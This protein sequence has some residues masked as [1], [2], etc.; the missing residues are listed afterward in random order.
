MKNNPSIVTR[1]SGS[2]RALA[3][4]TRTLIASA[5]VLAI[6]IV[7]NLLAGLLP[8]SVV[9]YDTTPAGQF[10]VSATSK[11]FVK[12]LKEDV[13][14]YVMCPGGAISPTMEAFL[15]RYEAASP[16]L[17]VEVVDSTVDAAFTEKYSGA[18]SMT[19]YSMVVASARRYRLI[20][21]TN[22]SYYYINGL[23]E[24]PAATY[25]QMVQSDKYMEIAYQYYTQYGIDI[26]KATPY[27]RGE[28]ALT[29]AIEYV[30][31]ETIPHL[32][33]SQ[34]HG[35]AALGKQLRSFFDQVGMTCDPL[36]ISKISA[37]PEDISTLLIHAPA[38]DLSESEAEMLISY[39]SA[40]GNILLI[41]STANATMPNLMKVAAAMGLSAHT[42]GVIS[43]GNANAYGDTATELKPSINSGH[44]ITSAG[45]ESGY[46]VLFPNA[47][48]IQIAS[49]LPKNVT[50]TTLFAASDAYLYDADGKEVSLGKAPVAV[51]ANNSQTGA[52][53]AW[54]ASVEAFSDEMVETKSGNGLYYL[55]MAASWQGKNFTSKLPTIEPV[56]LTLG[57]LETTG[58]AQII[59]PLL[60]IGV[61]PVGL[62]AIGIAVR[63]QRKRR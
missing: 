53:F 31:A 19:A 2:N 9:L 6:V 38:T 36:D 3:A 63:V 35:E 4:G 44:T 61:I 7:L 47:H 43:E 45:V 48:A 57:V 26:T 50:V 52:K 51:A 28:M 39:A 25:L 54:F 23:G 15:S 34:G 14:V 40:G 58:M 8:N 24:L 1:L 37:M 30:T 17:H 42:G 46:A 21:Y 18:S 11:S 27:F 60:L 10:S 29:Q 55:T 49:E 62:L 5:L 12:G 32:Y 41:T 13:T 56:D 59:F 16:Y 33:V 20:E 22:L